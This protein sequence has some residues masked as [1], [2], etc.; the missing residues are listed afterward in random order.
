MGWCRRQKVRSRRDGKVD[1]IGHGAGHKPKVKGLAE[2]RSLRVDEVRRSLG[3]GGLELGVVL[4]AGEVFDSAEGSQD[5]WGEVVG[6]SEL[7]G[8]GRAELLVVELG[9]EEGGGCGGE[10]FLKV[11]KEAVQEQTIDAAEDGEMV[12]EVQGG[13]RGHKNLWLHCSRTER[14]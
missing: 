6:R 3:D 13:G 2:G 8:P 5:G 14:A 1:G 9:G 11:L 4:G 7:G 12:E 10:N